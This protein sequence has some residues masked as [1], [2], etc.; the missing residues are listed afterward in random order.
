MPPTGRLCARSAPGAHPWW[1]FDS[2]RARRQ[3]RGW[4]PGVGRRYF[5]HLRL[6]AAVLSTNQGAGF[7]RLI[8][9]LAIRLPLEGAGKLLANQVEARFVSPRRAGVG[10]RFDSYFTFLP[11]SMF[12]SKASRRSF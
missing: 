10:I 7:V 8:R 12:V 4:L 5:H 9:R 2:L 1:R 3:F 11:V 6:A